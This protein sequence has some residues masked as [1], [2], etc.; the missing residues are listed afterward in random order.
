M[1][2]DI[3]AGDF[4]SLS[5]SV[6]FDELRKAG[7]VL[8]SSRAKGWRATFPSVFPI[9]D[10]DHVWV[11]RGSVTPTACHM[12]SSPSTNHHGQTVILAAN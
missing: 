4:N 8:A 11:G 7:F 9:Y 1:P 5:R 6:G 3:V 2:Y 12:F 10:I